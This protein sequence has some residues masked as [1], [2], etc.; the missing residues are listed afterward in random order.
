MRYLFESCGQLYLISRLKYR[1]CENNG[2][3]C[4][5]IL[6]QTWQE[7]ICFSWNS[8]PLSF[9]FTLLIFHELYFEQCS[10]SSILYCIP[11]YYKYLSLFQS[12]QVAGSYFAMAGCSAFCRNLHFHIFHPTLSWLAALDSGGIALPSADGVE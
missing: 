9:Y 4:F 12:T 8:K 5:E 10:I 2:L 6:S 11:I 3:F 1:P 7:Q